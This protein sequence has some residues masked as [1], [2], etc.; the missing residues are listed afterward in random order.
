MNEASYAYYYRD[1]ENEKQPDKTFV[2][3]FTDRSLYRP[4]QTV[5][6]KGLAVISNTVEKKGQVN[7]EYSTTLY[8][9][10]ANNENIDSIVV[11]AN[12]FGS[13]SGKFQL[14][15]GG[16]NGFF[17]LHTKDKIG[18]TSFRME[19]YK[20]PKFYVEYEKIKGTYKV[21]DKI[22]VTGVAKAYAGNNIDGALVKYRVVREA[23]FPYPWLFRRWWQPIGENLEIAHGELTTDKDGKFVIQ[24]TAIPDLKINKK[25]EPVF[26]Y[27]VYADVTDINGETRSGETGIS[28][29][30]KSII[31]KTD[32]PASA[33]VDS[34]RSLSIRTENMNGLVQTVIVKVSIKKLKEEK[35][36]I[37]KRYWERPDQ[38]VMSKGDYIKNFPYDE[39][40]NETD[41]ASWEKAEQVY[42]RS[43]SVKEL[44]TFK[45][46]PTTF[47]P[48][49]YE[50]EITTKDESNNEIK[51][52]HYIELIDEKLKQ[53]GHS[54]YLLRISLFSSFSFL[55]KTF[56]RT[57]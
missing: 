3:L 52:I 42:L 51:D 6:Y 57:G 56:T 28:A 49:F 24:F 11:R 5:Y 19:E 18:G 36:L 40:D 29:G 12:E 1:P 48:G 55:I 46:E 2:Y 9:R 43:D 45:L 7:N 13:F 37:R 15:S 47:Q 22:N 14:P 34:F 38:F 8:L 54:Q 17:G 26:E 23:R 33:A 31:L 53:L 25:F 20:R 32:I 21:N 44:S 35:R 39:Y 10:N 50:I 27:K 41:P 16:L 4:G 30:Y